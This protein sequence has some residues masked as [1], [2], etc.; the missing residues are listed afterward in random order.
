MPDKIRIIFMG[1]PDFAVGCLRSLDHDEIEV[2]AVVTVADK[3]AGRGRKLKP[4]AVKKYAEEKEY[5]VIQPEKLRDPSFLKTLE[6]YQADLFV[7]VA[8]RMLPKV[9]WEIP[10]KGTINL[11]ASLLPD[12]RGAAPINW[13]IINGEDKTGATTFFINENIDTGA[14][15][16][17]V[18]VP[19]SDDD[20]AGS[21][22]DKIMNKGAGLLLNTILQINEGTTNPTPQEKI[23]IEK[24]NAAP[25]IFKDDCLIN[26]NQSLVNVYNHIRGLNPFPGAHT[27]IELDGMKKQ[28]KIFDVR[29][30]TK[31]IDCKKIEIE[32][33]KFYVG[34]ESEALELVSIQ[35][36]GK[37]KMP[38]GDFLRGS[39]FET[40]KIHA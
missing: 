35:L 10:P 26:W 14:I 15:I 7:V 30:S 37:K 27:F 3:P 40:L 21:L 18:E 24:L 6:A 12:Y 25:K 8:F 5:P 39:R 28:L 34:T 23:K 38:A 22:H 36:E 9:V 17:Q 1:T 4:S 32:E 16:N 19:I 13:A 20:T 2:A 11:H 31:K 29:K 33:D